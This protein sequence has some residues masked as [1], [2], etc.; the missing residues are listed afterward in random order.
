MAKLTP[1][2]FPMLATANLCIMTNV[3]TDTN[4]LSFYFTFYFLKNFFMWLCWVLVTA[5][6]I[7]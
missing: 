7:F 2:L 5:C 1:I 6:G 3:W 4:I